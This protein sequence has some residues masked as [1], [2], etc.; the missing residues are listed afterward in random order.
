[1]NERKS[2]NLLVLFAIIAV[3]VMI[4][5]LVSLI[6][7]GVNIIKKEQGGEEPQEEIDEYSFYAGAEVG[8]E[9]SEI[10]EL[11]DTG[12]IK[13]EDYNRL[14]ATLKDY[15]D[16]PTKENKKKWNDLY[17]EIMG[18]ILENAGFPK[19]EA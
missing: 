4:F 7:I 2:R 6:V 8:V 12:V 1:M 18:S 10:E 9:A 17:Y 5:T 13:D 19:A 14:L 3:V 11:Y 16:H 15:M